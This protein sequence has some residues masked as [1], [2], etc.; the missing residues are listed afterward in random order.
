[1][2]PIEHIEHFLAKKLLSPKGY[3]QYSSG[4][5]SKS[6]L[7]HFC[8]RLQEISKAYVGHT[9][10]VTLSSPIKD[11]AAAQAYALYYSV[12]NAAK[13]IHLVPLLTFKSDAVSV[14]DVGCGPGTAA[15]ALLSSL[16][17][18]LSITCVE[19][20]APMRS[21]AERLL[22]QWEGMG[23]VRQ[24]SVVSSLAGC[25]GASFDLVIAANVLAEMERG[26]S[27][28]LVER[29]ASNVAHGGYLLLLEPGQQVH[30]RR[31]M[32]LRDRVI[33]GGELVP[34]FPCTRSDV[35]PMLS[36]SATDWCHG[37]LEWRQPRLNARF[38]DILGFNKHRI[39]YAAFLFQKGGTLRDGVRVM[40]EPVKGRSGIE[41]LLCGN[42]LYGIA[43]IRKGTRSENNRPLEKASVWDRL[44]VDP[45][46]VGDVKPETRIERL[47]M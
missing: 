31:L 36:S 32:E 34:Q 29:L 45:Q 38:D 28:R 25:E 3:S 17:H 15:L 41:A 14:L 11:I 7:A 13:L 37:S 35:C 1:M 24:L 2:T 26:A 18:A 12:I 20:S 33:A 23:S 21:V 6:E 16:S 47:P 40:T 27:A 30:T 39:K 43:R 9:V 46:E 42:E 8:E 5:V 19:S 22:S 10:G 44:R 4:D